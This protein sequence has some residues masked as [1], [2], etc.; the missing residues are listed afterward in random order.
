MCVG[1]DT[2]IYNKKYMFGPHPHFWHR[3]PK[4]LGISS[5]EID[6]STLCYVNEVTLGGQE[7][8]GLVWLPGGSCD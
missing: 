1:G 7:R 3:A 2:V 4:I 8:W 5:D 6:K